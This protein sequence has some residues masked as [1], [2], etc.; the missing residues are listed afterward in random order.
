MKH[1]LCIP[2]AFAF[3]LFISNFSAAQDTASLTGTI[4][5]QSGAA[6]PGAAVVVKNTATGTARELKSN[7][8]GEYLAP[9]LPPGQYDIAVAVKGFRKYKAVGVILGVAHNARID[10]TMKV[11]DVNIEV[12]VHGES[13]ARVNTQTSELAGTITGKEL[14]QLQ[15]NGRNFT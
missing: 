11:G 7:S 12:V 6:I 4:R 2:S 13:L 5:D 9:A 3:V 10:V 1:R 14:T 15:L 8:S